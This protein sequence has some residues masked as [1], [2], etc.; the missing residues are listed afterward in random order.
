MEKGKMKLFRRLHLYQACLGGGAGALGIVFPFSILKALNGHK[1]PAGRLV[2]KTPL[3]SSPSLRSWI[4]EADAVENSARSLF[5]LL[6]FLF[7]IYLPQEEMEAH[8]AWRD[9]SR[10]VW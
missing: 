1:V 2:T 10:R 7:F 8:Q 5:P 4:T 3:A 9:P 6:F